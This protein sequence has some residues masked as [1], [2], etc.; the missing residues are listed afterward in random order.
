[1]KIVDYIDELRR[2]TTTEISRFVA[3]MFFG[4]IFPFI[5]IWFFA[6]YCFG[7]KENVRHIFVFRIIAVATLVSLLYECFFLSVVLWQVLK[8]G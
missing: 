4:V 8:C 1:M 3:L 2:M 5:A 6:P 7:R